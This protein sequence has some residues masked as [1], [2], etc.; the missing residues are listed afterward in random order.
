[1]TTRKDI[2][3][4]AGVSTGTV[5]NVING[6]GNVDKELVMRVKRSIEKLHYT[7]N[8]NAKSL[9]SRQSKHIG[10]AL[11]EFEN[12]YHWEIIRGIEGYA[13]KRGYMTSTFLLDNNDTGKF[14]SICERRLC[15]LINFMTSEYP[16]KFL[17][18]LKN[19]NVK[20]VN[21]DIN[22]GSIIVNDYAEAMEEFFI[23]LKKL[24]HKKIGYVWSGDELR[25]NADMRG[26]AYR[27]LCKKY[28]MDEDDGLV[29]YSND[30]FTM[31]FD[32]GFSGC[33]ELLSRH[34]DVT[35]IFGANDLV[36]MGIIRALKEEGASVPDDISVI[37]CD[38]TKMSENY[39][40]S[41]STITFDKE[42]VGEDIARMII[43]KMDMPG[44]ENEVMHIGTSA[45]FRESL[46]AAKIMTK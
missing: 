16:D 14:E 24:G 2:A 8:H 41:I 35:A 12:P 5:S 28:G 34:P 36:A 25:F 19:Q 43:D 20:L 22:K 11:F 1:M 26:V 10:I 15:A 39:L 27:Y 42:K 3:L 31:S 46:G 29:V 37:G 4:D 7:P 30:P 17:D 9:A 18:I 23:R 40:P 21:F 32:I 45:V 6:K 33:K 44:Y 13:T 38:D